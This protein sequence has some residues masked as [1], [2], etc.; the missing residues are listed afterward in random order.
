MTAT[1]L[2]AAAA[3]AVSEVTTQAPLSLGD[4]QAAVQS[5]AAMTKT[6]GCDC[7][8]SS[9]CQQS[10]CPSGA[11]YAKLWPKRKGEAAAP[12]GETFTLPTTP[13]EWEPCAARAGEASWVP[14][15]TAAAATHTVAS[16][17]PGAFVTTIPTYYITIGAVGSA[18]DRAIEASFRSWSEAFFR[19]QGVLGKDPAAVERML[20]RSP[21]AVAKPQRAK[22]LAASAKGGWTS[23]R[24]FEGTHAAD[25]GAGVIGC[26]L[27]HL[28]TLKHAYD[29][30]AQMAVVVEADASPLLFPYWRA[31]LE[32]Y[33]AMLPA[34]W[35]VS[36]LNFLPKSSDLSFQI[37]FKHGAGEQGFEKRVFWGT[38]AYL[39]SRAGM[40][41][42]L[43]TLW[44]EAGGGWDL[45]EMFEKC[46]AFS[47]DDC[48][49][50][51]TSSEEPDFTGDV[52]WLGA[53]KT[54]RGT[55][56]ITEAF[57]ALPPFLTQ[58]PPETSLGH[59]S[60]VM[61]TCTDI[62]AAVELGAACR[63]RV[64]SAA[65]R[66]VLDVEPAGMQKMGG[67]GGCDMESSNCYPC[68][69]MPGR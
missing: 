16:I 24:F 38:G 50:G 8:V 1:E 34:G 61:S 6:V 20:S 13:A 22:I 69:W 39:V 19:V 42:V 66:A 25:I 35:Q 7:H 12:A 47:A 64:Q 31:S 26:L 17:K 15:F 44:D 62:A 10:C 46:P 9:C 40:Q 45:A 59:D 41:R 58:G 37:K 56:I 33:A 27:S 67:F 55:T 49:F 14:A 2:A 29:S 30:G 23:E 52:K 60:T 18:Q 63:G 48:L 51:F 32:E 57:L 5:L 65:D 21:A 68:D 36:Q 11:R 43:D 28:R 3:A 54:K 53:T 4:L